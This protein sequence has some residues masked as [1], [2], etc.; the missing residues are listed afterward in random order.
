MENI[1]LLIRALGFPF[2]T[3]FRVIRTCIFHLL[4]IFE[5]FFIPMVNTLLGCALVKLATSAS[6]LSTPGEGARH[7]HYCHWEIVFCRGC[8]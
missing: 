5:G 7:P 1:P 3:R 4:A 6:A 8:E 2:S